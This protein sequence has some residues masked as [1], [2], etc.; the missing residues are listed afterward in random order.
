MAVHQIASQVMAKTA[1]RSGMSPLDLARIDEDTPQAQQARLHLAN[2]FGPDLA[3][4][5]AMIRGEP[6]EGWYLERA[7]A[8]GALPP[9]SRV[10]VLEAHRLGPEPAV[11]EL[12]QIANEASFQMMLTT[13]PA[14]ASQLAGPR[15]AV[16]GNV[17]TAELSS[18]SVAQW[19]KVLATHR[20]QLLLSDLEWLL[21]RT[22]GRPRTTIDVFETCTKSM[23]IRTAWHRTVHI[24]LVRARDVLRLATAIH[25]YAPRLLQAI[26]DERPPYGAIENAPSQRVA[27]TLTRMRELDLIEQPAPRRWEISDPLLSAAVAKL[28]LIAA[29]AGAFGQDAEERHA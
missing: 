20:Q 10:V 13:R 1:D 17:F 7:L 25:P 2:H 19:Q 26:A 24:N 15:G 22:R 8:T 23:S 29:T 4:V 21:Q 14:H 27:H 18:P 6:V 11:W 5:A 3:D 16:F 12:R 28:S 9:G